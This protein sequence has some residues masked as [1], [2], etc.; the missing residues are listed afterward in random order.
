M[1]YNGSITVKKMIGNLETSFKSPS[2]LKG[3]DQCLNWTFKNLP[4]E[5]KSVLLQLLVFKTASFG[6][7]T[8][9]K[10]LSDDT[11]TETSC[12]T[13]STCAN[14][15]EFS[16]VIQLL[17]LKGYCVLEMHETLDADG[18][19]TQRCSLHPSVSEFLMDPRKN[20]LKTGYAEEIRK[21]EK[22]FVN[23]MKSSILIYSE[24][25]T[26]HPMEFLKIYNDNGVHIRTYLDLCLK[27]VQEIST[28]DSNKI[29]KVAFG[30]F[31]AKE[32]ADFIQKLVS[33]YQKSDDKANLLYWSAKLVERHL[34]LHSHS[35]IIWETINDIDD[36]Y[37]DSNPSGDI[38]SA[39][40]CYFLA[41]GRFLITGK[42][43]DIESASESL[44][45]AQNIF[46]HPNHK[47]A[48]ISERMAVLNSTGNCYF[49]TKP[50][51]SRL[52]W[53]KA[54]ALANEH[55]VNDSLK[56]TILS[57]IGSTYYQ[58]GV[59]SLKSSH[60][61]ESKECFEK[62]IEYLNEVIDHDKELKE[63]SRE[64]HAE[65]LMKRSFSY[66][67]LDHFEKAIEDVEG[68]LKIRSDN[69]PPFN[70]L[71]TITKW[72]LAFFLHRQAVYE[73]NRGEEQRRKGLSLIQK[74]VN[75]Y[76]TTYNSIMEGGLSTY[77]HL[78]EQIKNG[79]KKTLKVAGKR[80][81][82]PKFIKGYEVRYNFYKSQ[83]T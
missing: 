75:Q 51:K 28:I 13:D 19:I 46:E 45:V 67:N 8:A 15:L 72:R 61:S 5:L 22:N 76:E 71:L 54:Q 30:I 60:T 79:H 58:E 32:A 47:L 7:E 41:R 69:L 36:L 77:H 43:K 48:F 73:Y 59:Q 63:E 3:I 65:H 10:I 55:G 11:T 24:M 50:R 1:D 29:G 34:E 27:F 42:E 33:Q 82:I 2:L 16:V 35:D 20:S 44:I 37:I 49:E 80:D 62:S 40:A 21:A 6:V 38:L 9:L 66:I 52:Y 25:V 81:Q 14:G 4:N 64:A 26:T 39:I 57:N 12:S 83:L 78:Y 74:A 68:A 56:N 23:H 17:Q 70:Q 18:V 31:N 53:E